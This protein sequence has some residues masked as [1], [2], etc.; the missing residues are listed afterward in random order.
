MLRHLDT[1]LLT[2]GCLLVLGFLLLLFFYLVVDFKGISE[3]EG[4]EQ[5]DIARSLA[6]GEGFSTNIHT[7]RA[8][9]L[10]VQKSGTEA[11]RPAKSKR[12][13]HAPLLPVLTSLFFRLADP[14]QSLPEGETVF[15]LDRVI[16]AQSVLFFVLAIAVSF[17]LA[18]RLFDTR[19]ALATAILMILCE[20]MWLYTQS[21][22]AQMHM[23]FFFNL[24]LV[25][26]HEAY[27]RAT[28]DQQKSP[29]IPSL[30][31]GIAFA[32]LGL[33]HW[34]ALWPFWGILISVAFFFPQKRTITL[35][36][37][38]P[39]LLAALA[40]GARNI[41][42][43]GDPFG[44]GK[45]VFY[46]AL[47][48]SIRDNLLR[49]YSDTF[50]FSFNG[51]PAT[52]TVGS[53]EQLN[54][55]YP[56]LGA[57]IAAP[58][59]FI[60]LLHNYRKPDTRI[61]RWVILTGWAF[62]AL[63]MTAHG[64][65]GGR[66][67][68][69]NQIHILFMPVMS[70]FGL[71]LLSILWGRLQLRSSNT[72]ILRGHF[73]LAIFISAIPLLFSLPKKLNAGLY[74]RAAGRKQANWPPY[75]PPVFS[76]LSSRL[77]KGEYLVTDNPA[78]LGWYGNCPSIWL[79]L[80]SEQLARIAADLEQAEHSIAGILLT[81]NTTFLGFSNEVLNGTEAAWARLITYTAVSQTAPGI[82]PLANTPNFPY[83]VYHRLFPRNE[84]VFFGSKRLW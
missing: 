29:L 54:T 19:I 73:I 83:R 56:F 64:I 81:P 74:Q 21:G 5:A 65:E 3:A 10:A 33:T 45:E 15:A 58:L 72:F 2:Q 14:A 34:L 30:L 31:S 40:W 17:L 49:D 35:A 28:T 50:S 77:N 11:L 67:V 38:T 62:A 20:T 68:A 24:A 47:S 42:V 36:M 76:E 48:Q 44:M 53:V 57:V 6:L 18:R 71:A 9:H 25:F 13:S 70:A 32:L 66:A 37:G 80:N 1:K 43:Y 8:M 63:G 52:L 69:F 16:A 26:L 82:D 4:M 12:I 51:L 75:Y 39:V 7:P 78:G 60:A 27:I 46:S 55:L 84:M 41:A 23:L 59:F 22:L 79:P 61:F